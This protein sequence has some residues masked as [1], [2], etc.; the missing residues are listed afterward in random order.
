MELSHQAQGGVGRNPLSAWVTSTELGG[1][2]GVSESRDLPEGRKCSVQ[3]P[4]LLTF[5][6]AMDVPMDVNTATKHLIISEDLRTVRAG[7]QA[8]EGA[9]T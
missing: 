2:S 8:A 5:L 3:R 7:L 9:E 6:P 4:Y 1:G